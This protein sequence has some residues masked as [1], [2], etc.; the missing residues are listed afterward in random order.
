VHKR[1]H[2]LSKKFGVSEQGVAQSGDQLIASLGA[3]QGVGLLVD[4]KSRVHPSATTRIY[5]ESF[6]ECL[7]SQTLD[8]VGVHAAGDGSITREQTWI[9]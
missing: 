8:A 1:Q 3:E 6:E 4:L 7:Q 5:L 2:N 9:I